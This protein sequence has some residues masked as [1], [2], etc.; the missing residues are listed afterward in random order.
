MKRVLSVDP[1]TKSAEIAT[2]D[3]EGGLIITTT[4]D[5]TDII[6]NNKA[7]YA[8]TD[9]RE[10]YGDWAK[11]ASI[12]LAVFQDLNSLGICKGFAVVDQ[13]KF[14]DWL[15]DPE[16]RYFRTRPGRV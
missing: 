11:V 10:K 1:L 7:Q 5:C 6:E 12:P 4:Q 8:Q 15:N 13:K 3:G 14:K 2:D 9:E 16:N